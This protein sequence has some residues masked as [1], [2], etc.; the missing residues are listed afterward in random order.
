MNR[1]LRYTLTST[2]C[3]AASYQC[4]L[5]NNSGDYLSA[6][7]GIHPKS[8]NQVDSG[9]GSG[10]G[11]GVRTT[12]YDYALSADYS[13]NSAEGHKGKN[14]DA[15]NGKKYGLGVHASLARIEP[16][17]LDWS[18]L[19][20]AGLGYY[21]YN[22]SNATQNNDNLKRYQVGLFIGPSVDITQRASLDIQLHLMS[23]AKET[24][25]GGEAKR[26]NAFSGLL[27]KFQYYF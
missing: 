14:A 21:K 10:I 13:W 6:H 5:A 20:G 26:F 8:G 24:F 9:I 2:L 4:A 16:I 19:Y 18:F 17:T 1:L 3:L 23:Y 12:H 27:V 11:V 15:Q 22:D 25:D 7:V